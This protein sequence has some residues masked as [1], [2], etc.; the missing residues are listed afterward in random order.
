MNI[1]ASDLYRDLELDQLFLNQLKDLFDAEHRIRD[2]LPKFVEKAT[3]RQLK[4]VFLSH[5]RD[6]ELHI[7]RLQQVFRRI[8]EMPQRE[9]CDACRGLVK[10]A[11]YLLAAAGAS[12]VIDAGLLLAAQRIEHY[13]IGGYRWA[14]SLA[15]RLNNDEVAAILNLTLEEEKEMDLLLAAVAEITCARGITLARSVPQ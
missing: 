1:L 8:A 6:T 15:V 2:V 7:Q 3:S 5:I 4:D 13:E 14:Q 12:S 11:G 10:E 9:T